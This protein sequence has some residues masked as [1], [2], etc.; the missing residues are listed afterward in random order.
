[1]N[2][3]LIKTNEDLVKELDSLRKRVNELE[4]IETIR[5]E[6]EEELR[7][8][9]DKS[10]KYLDLVE[11]ALV[12][13]SDKGE[14]TLINQKGCR[15]LGYEES[16]LLGKDWFDTC[17]PKETRAEMKGI[18]KKLISK[19]IDI[20]QMNYYENP[21]ITKSGEE[22]SI[23]WHN[24]FL[25]DSNGKPI[26]LLSSGEDITERKQA[27]EKLKNKTYD[28]VNRVKELNCL[29]A[30]SSIIEEPGILLDEILQRAVEIIPPA[31]QYP[32][33]TC[34]KIKINGNEYK[35]E[36]YSEAKWHLL[37]D[38]YVNNAKVGFLEVCYIA[39][40][41]DDDNGPFLQEE[42]SLIKAIGKQLESIIER[43]K[44]EEELKNSLGKL[45]KAMEG[46]I[47]AMAIT[48]EMKDPYTAGH[49]R[50]VSKLACAIAKEM[51]V[52]EKDLDA[53]RMASAVHD[54]GKIYVP[55]EIL[56]KPGKISEIEYSII[57][58]HPQVAH[59]ILK[60]IDF[61]WPIA[62]IVIQ[63]H[64]RMDGSGY[65]AGLAGKDIL[66]EARILG[67]ADVVEAMASHRPYRP[68]LGIDKALDEIIKNKGK[69]YDSAVVDAC[70]N[71][72]NKTGFKF[73]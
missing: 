69:L 34:S 18:F 2:N 66:L 70:L 61:P 17:I 46:T 64:E 36:N 56:S 67:V 11:V 62:K 28:L 32:E 47:Q 65:P 3:E 15:I 52:G 54:L 1:M 49:E 39:E 16:E 53:I 9:R 55:A 71:L 48:A 43:K 73:D 14:I 41:H 26:G 38:L 20:Q 6:I 60:T 21:V 35:T 23:V 29:C 33:A 72:F 10:Q 44:A 27:E 13:L 12:A 5:S 57:K 51:G 37:C 19:E 50:R 24:T 25:K 7:N 40:Y 59:D 30:I 31:W 68:A 8:E 45:Q 58:T 42:R 22:K 4:K 63:H